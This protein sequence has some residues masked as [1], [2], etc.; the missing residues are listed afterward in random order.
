MLPAADAHDLLA[1]VLGAHRV[2]AEPEATRE[3]A[4]RCGQLPLALR[5]AAA[6][7]SANP[8][9]SIAAGLAELVADG[10]LAG[11]AV[12]G[13]ATS[14]VAAALMVSYESLP[15]DLRR[16]F[17][18]LGLFPGCEFTAHTAAALDNTTVAEANRRLRTLAAANLLEQH[19]AHTYRFHDLVRLFAAARAIDEDT[20]TD[21]DI[22]RER[23]FAAPPA[24]ACSSGA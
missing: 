7:I 3:L 23:L 4:R 15:T 2:A 10:L 17:R 14:S 5:I 11:L 13:A 9:T 21:R 12:D 1:D 20:G 22:A 16:L 6:N 18:R 24:P 8:N 19:A